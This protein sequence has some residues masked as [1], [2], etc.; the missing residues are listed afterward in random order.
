[1]IPDI[2][3]I[4]SH[5]ESEE[6][7]SKL[8]YIIL[9]SITLIVLIILLWLYFDAQSDVKT[10]ESQ[11]TTLQ[12]QRDEL[13]TK[14]DSLQTSNTGSLEQSVQVAETVSYPVSPIIDELQKLQPKHA[15]LRKYS[16]GENSVTI[17]FD[18]ETLNEVAHFI[19]RLNASPYFQDVKVNSVDHFLLGEE[20]S[21]DQINFNVAPR[22]STEI[23]LTIDQTYLA[24]G[25][26]NNETN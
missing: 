6:S 7:G 20:E 3:L 12:Q 16:F 8:I 25:G 2:N 11:E 19:S 15:Y 13:Q 24:T 21:S 14:L 17:S 22:Q 26:V 5:I 4:P 10:F 9:S 1:M 23:E 18:I